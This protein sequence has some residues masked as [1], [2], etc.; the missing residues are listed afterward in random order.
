MDSSTKERLRR[1]Y[2]GIIA[3]RS[4][5]SYGFR[6]ADALYLLTNFEYVADAADYIRSDAVQLHS[7]EKGQLVI[8]GLVIDDRHKIDQ[9]H[10]L[11]YLKTVIV[12][13]D[14]MAD[15]VRKQLPGVTIV[16][17]PEYKYLNSSLGRT[18]ITDVL[19]LFDSIDLGDG[20]YEI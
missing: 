18:R 2:R 20:V 11:N 13:S 16:I 5:P 3:D 10:L 17:D 8:E 19:N 14:E 9:L 12:H 4:V 7:N 1:W 15:R 6:V